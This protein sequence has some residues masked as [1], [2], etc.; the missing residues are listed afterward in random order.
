MPSP[1]VRTPDRRKPRG[2][3]LLVRTRQANRQCIIG[4][5]R[6]QGNFTQK[7]SRFE[8]INIL[9]KHRL[10]GRV[11]L[12]FWVTLQ[13]FGTHGHTTALPALA[14]VPATLELHNSQ[15]G[16]L[17]IWQRAYRQTIRRGN[18]G[19]GPRS[20]SGRKAREEPDVT[21]RVWSQRP[22]PPLPPA[23]LSPSPDVGNRPPPPATLDL[24]HCVSTDDGWRATAGR[25]RTSGM[26]GG[27]WGR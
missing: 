12:C 19:G 27:R 13:S 16:N 3:V 25:R 6:G 24:P 2:Y 20:E 7:T 15:F 4:G 14:R 17:A 5:E 9:G 1:R 21:D 11:T 10:G 22:P 26:A 18:G 8:C 23:S